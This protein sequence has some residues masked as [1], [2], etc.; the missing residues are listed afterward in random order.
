MITALTQIHVVLAKSAFE[1]NSLVLHQWST[2]SHILRY[3]QALFLEHMAEHRNIVGA[4][5]QELRKKRDLRQADIVARLNL[6]GW[7]L[8]R[9]TYAKIEAQIRCVTDDELLKIAAALGVGAADIL[10]LVTKGQKKSR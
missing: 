6:A 3:G 7:D 9:G 1:H 8:S 5:V 2:Q 4:V 10:G